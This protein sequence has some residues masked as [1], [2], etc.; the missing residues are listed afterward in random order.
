MSSGLALV[1]VWHQ[2]RCHA[3]WTAPCHLWNLQKTIISPHF[4]TIY[5]SFHFFLSWHSFNANQKSNWKKGKRTTGNEIKNYKQ[6]SKIKKRCHLLHLRSARTLKSAHRR[7]CFLGLF[8]FCVWLNRGALLFLFIVGVILWWRGGGGL[9]A[10]WWQRCAW[11]FFF[12]ASCFFQYP[13]HELLNSWFLGVFLQ[14]CAQLLVH[15]S[16]ICTP[17]FHRIWGKFNSTDPTYRGPLIK[18]LLKFN[19]SWAVFNSVFNF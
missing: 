5:V 3:C 17:I 2:A 15:K 16:W 8:L 9:G 12:L 4:C 1:H 11:L 14:P 7:W 13:S 6:V 10:V 18:L 19:F